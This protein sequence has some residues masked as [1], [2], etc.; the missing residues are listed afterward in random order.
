MTII[1]VFDSDAEEIET[2]ARELN[3]SIEEII[4]LLCEHMDE[5][6]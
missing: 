2:K 1:E 6:E 3:L 4:E 5:I